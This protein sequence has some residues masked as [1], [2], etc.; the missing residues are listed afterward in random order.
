VSA[1]AE[2][3]ALLKPPQPGLRLIHLHLGRLQPA[4]TAEQRQAIRQT[5]RTL[6]KQADAWRL[7]DIANGD[8]LM[9]YQGLA[10]T[11]AEAAC[12]EVAGLLPCASLS[13]S[14]PYNDGVA[15]LPPGGPLYDIV[16]LAADNT[17]RVLRYL[18][19]VGA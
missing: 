17:E 19:A 3:A 14:S 1:A 9:L 2:L 12:K 4:P 16:P 11:K 10:F 6:G 15:G 18:E 5:L 8:L 13:G 7:F